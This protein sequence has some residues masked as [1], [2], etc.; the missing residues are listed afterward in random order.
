MIVLVQFVAKTVEFQRFWDDF[1]SLL[2]SIFDVFFGFRWRLD[3]E[4]FFAK[5]WKNATHEKVAFDM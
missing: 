4:T 3:F 1:G 2:V 5:N